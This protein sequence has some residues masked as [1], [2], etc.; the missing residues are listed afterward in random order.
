[1]SDVAV[2]AT[3]RD[4]LMARLDR[5]GSAKQI[6]QVCATLGREFEYELLEAVAATDVPTLRAA[7]NQLVAAEI[8]Y[9]RGDL[10]VA[11]FI[12]KHSLIQ[13]TAYES[14]LRAT[15]RLQHGRIASVLKERFPAVAQKSPEVMG[16][17]C[18]EAGL[19]NESIEHFQNAGGAAAGRA[20]N[21]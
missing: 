7:L 6:A 5:L 18:A 11:S 1:M 2:P 17:H 16:H 20:A 10:P 12:F 19:V 4:T 13:E 3:L 15:R 9:K 14:L 8:L 21:D